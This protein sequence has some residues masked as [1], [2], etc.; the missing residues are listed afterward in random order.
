MGVENQRPF[1]ELEMPSLDSLKLSE[2]ES[3]PAVSA[4]LGWW[5]GDALQPVWGDRW[6]SALSAQLGWSQYSYDI[7]LPGRSSPTA[8]R[9][10]ILRPQLGTNVDYLVAT[11]T[12]W[13]TEFWFGA[14]VAVGRLMQ[15]QTSQTSVLLNQSLNKTYW[16]AGTHMRAVIDTHFL[17]SLQYRQRNFARQEGKTQHGIFA[18]GLAL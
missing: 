9:L 16:E 10:Q 15:S 3:N 4:T 18:L 6:R 13:N 14:E 7:G 5:F 1:G 11:S 12:S 17:V 8:A 2:F